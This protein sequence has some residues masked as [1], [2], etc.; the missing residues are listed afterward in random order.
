MRF[1]LSII[2]KALI[3]TM[4]TSWCTYPIFEYNWI[5]YVSIVSYISLVIPVYFL[6]KKEFSLNYLF[7]YMVPMLGIIF[8]VSLEHYPELIYK[9]EKKIQ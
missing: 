2:H 8:S 1:W 3:Y 4:V 5:G 9:W 7:L 6:I